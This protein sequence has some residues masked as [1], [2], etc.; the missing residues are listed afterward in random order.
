[1]AAHAWDNFTGAPQAVLCQHFLCAVMH[2]WSTGMNCAM[3]TRQTR[4][5]KVHGN[6]QSVSSGSSTYDPVSDKIAAELLAPMRDAEVVVAECKSESKTAP[7]LASKLKTRKQSSSPRPGD[8]KRSASAALKNEPLV[9]EYLEADDCTSSG[10]RK[11]LSKRESRLQKAANE[12]DESSLESL[13]F[14]QSLK[15]NVSKR[16]SRSRKS[17]QKNCCDDGDDEVKINAS[18]LSKVNTQVSQS[19]SEDF[20]FE[21]NFTEPDVRKNA[22]RSSVQNKQPSKKNPEGKTEPRATSEYFEVEHSRA[23]LENLCGK[24]PQGRKSTKAPKQPLERSWKLQKWIEA[25][26]KALAI[27]RKA[28]ANVAER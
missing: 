6:G 2:T 20:E 16:A 18:G 28:A 24:R 19:E 12:T 5:R 3:S 11:T 7:S 13:Q 22:K 21:P 1:M 9:S 15:E 8:N 17:R 27:G 10:N 23:K 14:F 4:S 25:A 26:A